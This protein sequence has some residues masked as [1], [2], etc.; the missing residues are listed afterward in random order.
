MLKKKGNKGINNIIRG[1]LCIIF[2]GDLW[3]QARGDTITRKKKCDLEGTTILLARLVL[4]EKIFFMSKT[5]V[6]Y[7]GLKIDIQQTVSKQFAS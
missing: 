2:R 1:D 4:I 3:D 6:E 7:I 5:R